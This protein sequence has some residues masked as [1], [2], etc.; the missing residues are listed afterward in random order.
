MESGGIKVHKFRPS[1]IKSKKQQSGLQ[2]NGHQVKPSNSKIYL[3][4]DSNLSE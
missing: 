2:E 1:I 3:N 4:S